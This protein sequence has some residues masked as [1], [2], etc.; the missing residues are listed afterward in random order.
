MFKAGELSILLSLIERWCS[1]GERDMKDRSGRGQAQRVWD[2]GSH[3]VAPPSA[4]VCFHASCGEADAILQKLR[5]SEVGG[6]GKT[7]PIST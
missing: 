3:S 5:F 2:P 6:E 7:L 1:T 4:V